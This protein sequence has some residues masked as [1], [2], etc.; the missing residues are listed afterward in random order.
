MAKRAVISQLTI[1]LVVTLFFSCE[2]QEFYP[3]SSTN[4]DAESARLSSANS[5]ALPNQSIYYWADLLVRNV[6][7]AN[8]VYDTSR[9]SVTWA[10]QNGARIYFSATV[11]SGFLTKLLIQTYG[12]S[13]S[14][15]RTWTGSTN[16]HASNYYNEIITRDH[17]T[18]ITAVSQIK[19]GDII[20]MQY[21]AGT[22][23]STGHVMVVV[24]PPTLR[25]ASAPLVTG[26]SQ[27]EVQIMD[28]S[29]TG[30][31]SSDTRYVSSGVWNTGVGRGIFRLYVAAN[32]TISGYSWSTYSSSVY[33]RQTDRPLAVGRLIP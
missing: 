19:Q 11:C 25:T 15:F 14:Y 29:S 33:Y 26:T 24:A 23:T 21:P 32:G 30:H 2:K 7:P 8:N 27:Y 13:T 3:L 4:P 1:V 31:G 17:F 12:Y 20:A 10:G 28:C 5:S 22:S 6:L 16:P 18:N 9:D